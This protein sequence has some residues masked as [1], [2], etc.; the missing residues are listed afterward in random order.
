MPSSLNQQGIAAT[1]AFR[2]EV[3]WRSLVFSMGFY[4]L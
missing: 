2:G 4:G 3:G 1:M